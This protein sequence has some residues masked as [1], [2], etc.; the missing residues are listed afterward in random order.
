MLV[1]RFSSPDLEHLYSTL[2]K[3][4][5]RLTAS[6]HDSYLIPVLQAMPRTSS[7]LENWVQGIAGS[8]LKKPVDAWQD[9]DLEVFK[10][11][12]IDYT[13]R[14]E[15]LALL[16]G[17]DSVTDDVHVI[18]VM[19]PNGCAGRTVVRVESMTSKV[20]QVLEQISRL[21]IDEKYAVLGILAKR[22]V[23]GGDDDG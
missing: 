21:S 5:K 11:R 12:L 4:A 10:V 9:D 20:E 2:N 8:V 23:L 1:E 19:G 3:R 15:Q 18:G 16:A 17:I 6:C 13:E 22:L 7:D 14:I